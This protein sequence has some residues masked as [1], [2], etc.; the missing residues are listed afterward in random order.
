MARFKQGIEVFEAP[1]LVSQTDQPE[2]VYRAWARGIGYGK[3]R[4]TDGEVIGHPSQ[5][6]VHDE[7]VEADLERVARLYHASLEVFQKEWE[8]VLN[9]AQRVA[10]A[11]WLE[12]E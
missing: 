12:V 8:D 7:R 5:V 4:D 3:V 1:A 6:Y 10:D 2:A 11:P 9:R